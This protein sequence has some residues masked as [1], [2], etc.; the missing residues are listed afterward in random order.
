MRVTQGRID[1]TLATYMAEES[2]RALHWML[3]TGIVWMPEN[4]TLIDGKRYFEPGAYLHPKGGGPGHSRNGA[5]LPTAWGSKVRVQ[6]QGRGDPR[7]SSPGRRRARH[8]CERS[9]T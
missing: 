1:A 8:R 9:T 6:Q 3:E 7:R 5:G 4:S 2:N